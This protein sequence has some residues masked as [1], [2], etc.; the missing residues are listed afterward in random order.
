MPIDEKFVSV[1]MGEKKKQRMTFERLAKFCNIGTQT[2]MRW[3][4]QG[5]ANTSLATAES[6]LNKLGYKIVIKKLGE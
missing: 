3:H 1:L 2:I 5:Y 6:I 4:N